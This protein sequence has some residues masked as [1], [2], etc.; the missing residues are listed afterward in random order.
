MT[1]L[2][3]TPHLL[4]GVAFMAAVLGMVSSS[5]LGKVFKPEFDG[6]GSNVDAQV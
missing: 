3:G 2:E 1:I 4:G 5:G 6:I